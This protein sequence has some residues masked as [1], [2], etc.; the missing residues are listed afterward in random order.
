MGLKSSSFAAAVIEAMIEFLSVQLLV[1][2][3]QMEKNEDRKQF[4]NGLRGYKQGTLGP[5]LPKQG[6]FITAIYTERS[7]CHSV[8]CTNYTRAI[9][10]M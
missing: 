7:I 4:R 10:D 6:D 5:F 8:S 2:E 9:I 3:M 1:L